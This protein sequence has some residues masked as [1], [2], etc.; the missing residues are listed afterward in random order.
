VVADRD[1]RTAVRPLL[2]CLTVDEAVY[3]RH[4]DLQAAIVSGTLRNLTSHW[5]TSGYFEGRVGHEYGVFAM[6]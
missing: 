5:R 1:L 4:V 6:P 3:G 2:A